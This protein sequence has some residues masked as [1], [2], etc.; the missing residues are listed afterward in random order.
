MKV[1]LLFLIGVSLGFAQPKNLYA[2]VD[3]KMD[4]IP[5]QATLTTEAIASYINT[6]FKSDNDKVRA[7]F[8]WIATNISYDIEH[9]DSIDYA[10]SS[11]DKIK[12]T[13]LNR[14]GVCIHY[15][16]VFNDIIQKLGLNSYIIY[17]YTKQNGKIDTLSHSW[18]AVKIDGIW[19]LYDPT[20]AAGYINNKKF[21]KK[22]NNQFYKVTPL[23]FISSHMPFDYLWQFSNYPITN[24]QFVDGKIQLDKTKLK[25]DYVTQLEQYAQ[26]SELDKVFISLKRIENNGV[27]NPLIQQMVLSQK[28]DVE[29]LQNNDAMLRYNAISDDY[30]SAIS[31][32]NDFIYYRN[33]KFKPAI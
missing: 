14:K 27:I 4:A 16:E 30:N 25:F 9:I 19:W 7:T 31:L 15:A 33:I 3:A 17:G 22:L 21:F 29:A 18:C 5:K 23:Q 12:N 8:Y 2:L 26:S 11:P 32:F 10:E 28:S 20:W 6:N 13:L 1:V 24:Q